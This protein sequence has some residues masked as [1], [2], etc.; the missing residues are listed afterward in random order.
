MTLV[1]LWTL[2]PAPVKSGRTSFWHVKQAAK[3]AAVDNRT[4]A[5]RSATEQYL[6]ARWS[7]LG[8]Q[9]ELAKPWH[10]RTIARAEYSY[11]DD[12]KKAI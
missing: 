10:S 4:A 12:D 11:D 2:R 6:Q 3:T 1:R 5:Y 8:N 9:A 7:S